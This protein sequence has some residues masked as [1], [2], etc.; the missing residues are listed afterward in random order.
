M[1]NL[2]VY[3]LAINSDGYIY[4]GT[5]GYGIFRSIESTVGIENYENSTMPA[6]FYLEQ[7]YPNPFNPSTTIRYGV[8]KFTKVALKI[9]NLT[10]QEVRTL[11][12]ENQSAGYRSVIWDGKNNLGQS[13]S[14][15]IYIYRLQTP[16]FVKTKKLLL[17]K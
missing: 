13:V 9:Y 16:E 4:A 7:N 14:S 6:S 8:P 2:I 3:S 1:T 17:L 12:D 10:G 15:G 11:I 5:W